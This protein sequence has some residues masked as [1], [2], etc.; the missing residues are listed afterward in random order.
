[1]SH[2]D[3]KVC[4]HTNDVNC[5]NCRHTFTLPGNSNG[6]YVTV[7]TVPTYT[8]KHGM[9]QSVGWSTCYHCAQEANTKMLIESVCAVLESDPMLAARLRKTLGLKNP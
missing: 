1:M 5:E 2:N 3:V 4:M 7:S 9:V 6:P 8:C